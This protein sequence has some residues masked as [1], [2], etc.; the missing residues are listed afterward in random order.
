VCAPSYNIGTELPKDSDFGR[1]EAAEAARHLS[2]PHFNH[3]CQGRLSL[4]GNLSFYMGIFVSMSA[5]YPGEPSLIMAKSWLK[6]GFGGDG[7]RRKCVA[8]RKYQAS[9][10]N[11][12]ASRHLLLVVDTARHGRRS[13]PVR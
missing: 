9:H 6:N 2:A 1:H 8:V 13:D 4:I 11:V 10:R 3:D 12:Q 5:G 7:L